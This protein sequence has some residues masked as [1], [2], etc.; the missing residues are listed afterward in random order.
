MYFCP[1]CMSLLYPE[2]DRDL[3]FSCNVCPYIY[4]LR[5][6][7]SNVESRKT[8][9][10]EKVFGGD[11]EL[12]YASKCTVRCP[13]CPNEEALFLEIQT[14]S[15]DEPTTIFYQCTKCRHDWKE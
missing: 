4:K 9:T 15:A 1:L 6:Q 3:H 8:K 2:Q 14:R 10:I 11:D 7:F 13:R 12:R 5:S